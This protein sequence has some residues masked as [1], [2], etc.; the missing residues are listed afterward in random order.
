MDHKL[1]V[2]ELRAQLEDSD[3]HLSFYLENSLNMTLEIIDVQYDNTE[4]KIRVLL[5]PI[6]Y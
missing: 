2:D 6:H 4:N 1:G 5:R 3:K